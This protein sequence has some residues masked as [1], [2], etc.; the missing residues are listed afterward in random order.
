[1]VG[2]FAS[3]CYSGDVGP[4]VSEHGFE[5][6]ASVGQ[7]RALGDDVDAVV[8]TAAGGADVETPMGGGGGDELDGDVDGVGLVAVFGGGVAQADVVAGVVSRKGDGA[9]ATMMGTR[10]A[11]HRGGWR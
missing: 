8:V 6:V 1:L 11:N 7:V 10:S 9:V 5:D 3:L 4:V 2:E